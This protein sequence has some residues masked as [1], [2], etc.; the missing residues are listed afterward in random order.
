VHSYLYPL[1]KKDIDIILNLCICKSIFLILRQ[2]QRLTAALL[3]SRLAGV[4]KYFLKAVNRLIF[5][6]LL[7]IDSAHRSAASF[8]QGVIRNFAPFPIEN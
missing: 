4:L 8:S 5:G 2:T 1:L 3:F 7:Y 6:Y